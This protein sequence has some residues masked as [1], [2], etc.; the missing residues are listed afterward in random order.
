LRQR[1]KRRYQAAAVIGESV[2][3]SQH[4]PFVKFSSRHDAVG[5]K[6]PQMCG[7]DFVRDAWDVTLEI[8]EPSRA[9]PQLA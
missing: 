8:V 5:F 4:R 7:Q 2:F 6:F 9:V 1:I 3:R